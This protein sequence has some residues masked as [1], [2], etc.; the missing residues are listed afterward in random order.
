MTPKKAEL[1]RCSAW[2]CRNKEPQKT[3]EIEVNVENDDY[4]GITTIQLC[5]QCLSDMLE[6]V[7]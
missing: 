5:G 3:A 6:E 4:E 1:G 7:E 2:I